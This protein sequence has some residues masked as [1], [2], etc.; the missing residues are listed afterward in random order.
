MRLQDWFMKRKSESF[1][2]QPDDLDQQEAPNQQGRQSDK[3]KN[4]SS[5]SEGHRSRKRFP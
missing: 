1:T 3:A 4:D 2:S 5:H